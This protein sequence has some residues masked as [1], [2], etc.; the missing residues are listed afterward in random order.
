MKNKILYIVTSLV[1]FVGILFV[2]NNVFAS[3]YDYTINSYDV[4]MSVNENNTFDITENIS[5]F[6]NV[7]KHGIYR[8]I[9]TL[10]NVKR[11]DGTESTIRA[12]IT[13]LKVS[14]EYSVSTSSNEKEIKIGNNDKTYTGKKDYVISYNYN[15]GKDKLKDKDELYFNLIGPN[16]DTTISNFTF[17]ITMPKDFDKSKIGFSSGEY[18]STYNDKI[19]YNVDGNVIT[20]KYNGTLNSFE[21]L[22]IRIELPDGYFLKQSK[23][24]GFFNVI[25]ILIPI[26]L[27]VVSYIFWHKY[28]KDKKVIETVEFYPPEAMNSLEVG[29]SYKGYAESKDVTSLLIYLADKGYL[30]IEEFEETTLKI[31]KSKSFKII[32]LKEYDGD[33][34]EEKLFFNGLFLSGDEVKKSD[35]V[36][37]FYLT[38]NKVISSISSKENKEKLFEKGIFKN[39]L[40]I[41]CCIIF[42]FMFI[43]IRPL[44]N[45]GMDISSICISQLIGIAFISILVFLL[46]SINGNMMVVINIFVALVSSLIF[47]GSAI[48]ESNIYIVTFIIGFICISIDL[49]LS[50]LISR[51]TEYGNEILGKIRG[52]KNFL[53]TA[54]KN[55]LEQ[56]VEQ[57]PKYFYNILPYTYVLGV[58]NKW[59]KKFESINIQPPD[60]YYSPSGFDMIVFSDFISSTMSSAN[61]A[62]TSSPNS[63]SGGGFSGGGFSGGG[64]GGGGGGSW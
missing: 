52:F 21:A 36:D 6:F 22:T 17:K 15:I 20:G 7:Q 46:S 53:L 62:M 14:D 2:N 57:D 1:I 45:Y 64:S 42:T 58:S 32:K 11:T 18:G 38:T 16:W 44:Y 60:W 55:K 4:N 10:N 31:I 56:L 54:E 50:K 5:A 63:S 41:L 40:V 61:S 35:L 29:F 37:M 25:C 48:F 28:G 43:T 12:K 26:L 19:T 33:S 49:I 13:N 39:K 30:K 23:F 3:S 9:P 24:E 8:N 59:M 51:R 27:L 34:K 47:L